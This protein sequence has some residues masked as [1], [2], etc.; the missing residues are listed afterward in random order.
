LI[1]VAG[2]RPR[3]VNAKAGRIHG[4]RRN[5]PEPLGG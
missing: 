1:G 2:D 4:E 3:V 5:E